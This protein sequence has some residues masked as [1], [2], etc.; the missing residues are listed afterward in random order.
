M[1]STDVTTRVR[2]LDLQALLAPASVA[3]IGASPDVDRHPGRAVANLL[4]TGYRGAIHPVNPSYDEVL[5]LPCVPTVADAGPVDTA[6]VLVGAGRVLDVVKQCVETG[7]RYVVVCTSGF[8]EEGAAG[9]DLQRRL[10]ELAQR[11]ETRVIGPNCIG[12]L[13]PVDSVVATPTFNIAPDLLPGPVA[14]V[15]QSGGIGVNIVN[16]AGTQSRDVN[17]SYEM[18]T[19][20]TRWLTASVAARSAQ[21]HTSVIGFSAD[22]LPRR[23]EELHAFTL[24][25]KSFMHYVWLVL[26]ALMPV[27]TIAMAIRVIRAKGMPR[28]WLWAV[29]ALIASPA[30]TLNWTTGQARLA[31]NLFILF[32]AAFGR[33][34]AA[35]P[36]LL[37]FA[38]PIGAFVAYLRFR[39]WR[40][41]R[42]A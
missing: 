1:T 20:G 41:A 24:A 21:G 11:S 29:V 8:A 16:H 2:E 38:M 13:S 4:R 40:N 7:V 25:D 33:P 42:S 39:A 27:V 26:A 23:L 3:V 37:T 6:Y 14:V 32:G 35:A 15:S 10:G 17:L 22:V 28:R 34:G 36:W 18:P 12:V 30:F 9:R 19:T 5:G 31:N